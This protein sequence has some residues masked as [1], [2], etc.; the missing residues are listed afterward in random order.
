MLCN[1]V[2]RLFPPLFIPIRGM[3]GYWREWGGRRRHRAQML[4]QLQHRGD[5]RVNGQ[6]QTCA[7]CVRGILGRQLQSQLIHLTDL[8]VEAE[9]NS[10]R[11]RQRTKEKCEKVK[12]WEVA[13]LSSEV[14]DTNSGDAIKTSS[15]RVIFTRSSQPKTQSVVAPDA[16]F[17]LFS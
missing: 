12:D 4:A 11:V 5:A 6:C 8:E 7:D 1:R 13:M 3:A 10:A 2:S 16:T 15:I 14:G 17:A 9:V